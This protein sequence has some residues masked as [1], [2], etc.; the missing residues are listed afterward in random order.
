MLFIIGCSRLFGAILGLDHV[1]DERTG[2][3]VCF[4]Q[5][6][7]VLF[8]QRPTS[9][10]FMHVSILYIRQRYLVAAPT[11]SSTAATLFLLLLF[12]R[13]FRLLLLFTRRHIGR[14]QRHIAAVYTVYRAVQVALLLTHRR[15]VRYRFMYF[16]H[17]VRVAVIQIRRLDREQVDGISQRRRR[18]DANVARVELFPIL[19]IPN[20]AQILIGRVVVVVVDIEPIRRQRVGFHVIVFVERRC[21]GVYHRC[22]GRRVQIIIITTIIVGVVVTVSLTVVIVGQVARAGNQ[23]PIDDQ[24]LMIVRPDLIYGRLSR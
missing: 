7:R 17:R 23:I 12:S 20:F 9:A 1:L 21:G 4:A 10:L 13:R 14:H 3:F 5:I 11:S 2:V 8:V 15:I 18:R 16:A 19:L 6:G 24:H 22:C